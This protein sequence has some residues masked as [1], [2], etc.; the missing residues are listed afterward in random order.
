M[1]VGGG[2]GRGGGPRAPT[3]LG[4]RALIYVHIS[5]IKS[6]N[7]CICNLIMPT[8]GAQIYSQL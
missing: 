8:M 1:V 5:S 7:E 2:N 6:L 4:R 3:F